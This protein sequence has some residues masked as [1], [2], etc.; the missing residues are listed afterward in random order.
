[1]E[2][3]ITIAAAITGI[4]SHVLY[5]N[6][7]EH[8]L[9]GFLYAEILGTVVAALAATS[10]F[11]PEAVPFSV[12]DIFLAVVL[13]I[14]GLCLSLLVYRLFLHPL[15]NFPGPKAAKWTSLWFSSRLRKA[16]AHRKV[17]QLHQKYGEFVRVGSSDLSIVHPAGVTAVYGSKSKCV[18]GAWYDLTHPMISLQTTR[19]KDL[20]RARRRIWSDAFSDKALSGYEHRMK[21]YRAKLLGHISHCADTS[22]PVDVTKWFNFY[23]FDVMGDLAFGSSFKMLETSEQ[24]WALTLLQAGLTPLSLHLPM[25]FFRFFMDIPGLGRDWFR[26]MKYCCE[27]VDERISAKVDSPDIMATLLKA[28]NKDLNPRERRKLLEGDSQ[29]IIVAGS[30]TTAATLTNLLY[31]LVKNSKYIDMVRD[32][33]TPFVQ[34]SFVDFR[35]I[36][37]LPILNGVI[38]ETL[39]M[40]PPVPTTLSRRTPPGGI[41]VGDIHVPGDMTVWCPQY[42]IGRKRWYS[43]PDMVKEKSAF[44]PFSTGAYACIGK[45]LAL[46][47]IRN[48]FS[49]IISRYDISLGV[50]DDLANFEQ[51]TKDHFTLGLPS[52]R[53]RFT[54][55]IT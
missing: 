13:Y 53:V 28:P 24:H 54:Q 51:R 12:N 11:W 2:W 22:I 8:H 25:W 20:H 21:A 14:C 50:V 46:Q 32:E 55:R 17:L 34:G 49:E 3:L 9:Y 37:N 6:R 48:T 10:S 40:H 23:T 41:M 35:N 26:F 43:R 36:Q 5:F 19:D 15:R 45:S 4:L 16:D 31:E 52:L 30:D 47:N 7:G 42:A 44:A 29:L 39:R 18:K 33:L 27:R 1:M 38:Y